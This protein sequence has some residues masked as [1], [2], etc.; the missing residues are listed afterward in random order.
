MKC[1]L[2]LILSACFSVITSSDVNRTACETDSGTRYELSISDAASRTGCLAEGDVSLAVQKLSSA[3]SQ[4]EEHRVRHL[5][6]DNAKRSPRCR[7]QVIAALMSAM[8]KP[9]LDFRRDQA[10]YYLWSD[11][12][13]LLGDLRAAE[14]LDLLISHLDLNDGTSSVNMIHQPALGGVIKM[15]SIAIPKLE[16]VLRQSPDRNMRRYAVFCIARIGGQTGKRALK[17]DLP[18]ES[19]RCVSQFIRVSINALDNKRLPNQIT[20]KDRGKW[21][22]AFLCNE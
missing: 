13:E 12:A 2:A 10:S 22:S 15:G 1:G 7:K 5:L 18:S 14:A 20:S 21:F 16:A 9:N 11:G 17:H 19:D 8:D 3:Q 6:L 4:S